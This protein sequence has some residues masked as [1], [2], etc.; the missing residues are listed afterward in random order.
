M[1]FASLRCCVF[2]GRAPSIYHVECLLC[3][4]LCIEVCISFSHSLEGFS[5]AALV[6]RIHLRIDRYKGL[7]DVEADVRHGISGQSYEVLRELLAGCLIVH[8]VLHLV[9]HMHSLYSKH[10]AFMSH[11]LVKLTLNDSEQPSLIKQRL[12][13]FDYCVGRLFS[14]HEDWVDEHIDERRLHLCLEGLSLDILA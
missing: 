11:Q 4:V 1:L 6:L 8:V 5:G 13:Q 2:F 3:V 12:A 14:D 10:E 9:N 7:R